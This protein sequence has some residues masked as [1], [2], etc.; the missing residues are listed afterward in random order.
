MTELLALPGWQVPP[1]TL[2]DWVAA[3]TAQGASVV[4]ARESSSAFWLEMNALR[5][6]GYA[7]MD[8]QHV[9]AINFELAVPDPEPA[10]RI[11]QAAAS[12]LGWEIHEDDEH[13]DDDED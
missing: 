12:A 9:E 6:R 4:V 13:E 7:V 11:I 3:L 5:S 2:D 1:R 10:S 8:S